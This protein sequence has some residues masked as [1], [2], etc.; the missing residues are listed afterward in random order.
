MDIIYLA[1]DF[2]EEQT[3]DLKEKRKRGKKITFKD[4]KPFLRGIGALIEDK[5][6]LEEA[7]KKNMWYAT[8]LRI[9][10]KTIKEIAK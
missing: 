1:L 5:E 4:V 7:G 10:S 8:G 2:I 9:A 6:I 3:H